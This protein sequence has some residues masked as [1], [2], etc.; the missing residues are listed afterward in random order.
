MT[1]IATNLKNTQ[2]DV[3]NLDNVTQ[4]TQ[5]PTN[6][7]VFTAHFIG[8]DSVQVAKTAVPEANESY[9][10][11]PNSDPG[12]TALYV[13]EID[14]EGKQEFTFPIVAWRVSPVYG[15]QIPVVAGGFQ[16]EHPGEVKGWAIVGKDGM[17][18]PLEFDRFPCTRE[19]FLASQ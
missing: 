14:G 15:N 18:F 13:A 10:V 4:F 3:I 2:N 8:G 16:I 5:S 17:C 19:E 1:F 7:E 9:V 11:V 12:V 6:P